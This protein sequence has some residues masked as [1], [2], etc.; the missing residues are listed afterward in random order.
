[1]I[2]ADTASWVISSIIM[3]EAVPEKALAG[4]AM[5]LPPLCLTHE[6]IGLDHEYIMSFLLNASAFWFFLAISGLHF[7][8]LLLFLWSLF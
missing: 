8:I 5:A 6:F 2:S 3:N 4:K 1:M 7:V